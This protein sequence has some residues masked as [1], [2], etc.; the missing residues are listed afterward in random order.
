MTSVLKRMV[1]IWNSEE[2]IQRLRKHKLAIIAD[3]DSDFDNVIQTITI[4]NQYSFEMM[5]S[6]DRYDA[7]ALLELMQC[8]QGVNLY[9]KQ[10]QVT[11]HEGIQRFFSRYTLSRFN[12]MRYAIR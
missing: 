10:I 11:W 2:L 9:R 1:N 5:I 7:F 6:K 3:R 4:R 12:V 8:P